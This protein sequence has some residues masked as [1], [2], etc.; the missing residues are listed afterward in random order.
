VEYYDVFFLCVY[1]QFTGLAIALKHIALQG[2]VHGDINSNNVLVY[3]DGRLPRLI[4]NDFG[5]LQPWTLRLKEER[6]GTSA[7]GSRNR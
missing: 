2:Y 6:W 1:G 4:I 7:E 5:T 3:L